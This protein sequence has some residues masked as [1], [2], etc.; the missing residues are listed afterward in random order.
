MNRR[1]PSV[2]RRQN[3][4]ELLLSSAGRDERRLAT[5][6]TAVRNCGHSA[7]IGRVGD[8]CPVQHNAY[9]SNFAGKG[10]RSSAAVPDLGTRRTRCHDPSA[11]STD[12]KRCLCCGVVVDNVPSCQ[13]ISESR[14][15]TPP[16]LLTSPTAWANSPAHWPDQPSPSAG[17]AS[18]PVVAEPGEPAVATSNPRLPR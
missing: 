2:G 18:M 14:Y 3:H 11:G 6:T 8:Q 9:A 13:V 5:A 10:G 12:R 15:R 17:R 16:R 1:S 7:T 4:N